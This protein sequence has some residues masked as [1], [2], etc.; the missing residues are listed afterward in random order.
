MRFILKNHSWTLWALSVAIFCVAGAGI[1]SQVGGKRHIRIEGE[2]LWGGQDS[3]QQKILL[4]HSYSREYSWVDAVNQGLHSIL[5]EKPG[6]TI[7][8]FYMDA[9]R[10]PE[11]AH[12]TE[13]GR[14]ALDLVQRMHPSLIIASDDEAQKYFITR[15]GNVSKAPV[16]FLGVNSDPKDYGYPRP[17]ITGVLERPFVDQAVAYCGKILPHLRRIAFLSDSSSTTLGLENWV[18]QSKSAKLINRYMIP[19]TF[20]QWQESV[21]W[22]NQNSDAILV[23]VYHSLQK[24][25]HDTISMD[26]REVMAWTRRNAKVPRIALIG[27]GID[28]GAV[29]GVAESGAQQGMEAGRLVLRILNGESPDSISFVEPLHGQTQ[30]N[31]QAARELN[32][33]IAQHFIDSAAVVK[34]REP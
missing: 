1:L 24:S 30:L 27:F 33:R 22:A 7:D 11:D 12:Q 28:D 18:K 6:L 17:G 31:L 25:E 15:L 19:H 23:Y 4:V 16:V 5:V 10:F 29:C 9:K 8:E 2:D 26:P 34:G 3:L 14:R 21:R 32:I 20:A 13:A